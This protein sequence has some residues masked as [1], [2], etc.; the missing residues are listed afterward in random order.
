[1]ASTEP[2]LIDLYSSGTLVNKYKSC[3]RIINID[4]WQIQEG[5]LRLKAL[6]PFSRNLV[7]Y[8]CQCCILI[9]YATHYLFV[10]R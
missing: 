10:D 1:M 9:G 7:E 8:Y 6:L 3:V 2:G 4:H 5:L